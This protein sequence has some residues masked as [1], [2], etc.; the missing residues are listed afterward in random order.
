MTSVRH[1]K[2]MASGDDPMTSTDTERS[3]P[4]A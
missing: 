4:G 3:I 2:S 1:E